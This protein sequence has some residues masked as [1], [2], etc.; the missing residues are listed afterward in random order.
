MKLNSDIPTC[1]LCIDSQNIVAFK[2][3]FSTRNGI[4][5]WFH[6]QGIVSGKYREKSPEENGIR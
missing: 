2:V 1:V 5:L 6:S 4:L 3:D